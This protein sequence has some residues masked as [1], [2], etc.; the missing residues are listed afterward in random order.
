MT[1]KNLEERKLI[2]VALSELYLD[3]ELQESDLRYMARI[4]LESPF[5]LNK[6][7][8]IDRDEV[9]PVLFSNLLNPTG[10]WGFNEKRLAESIVSWMEKRSKLDIL[11]VHCVYPLYSRVNRSYWKKI[12][13]VYNQA[14]G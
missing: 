10:E 3:I 8:L 2:W 11:A 7:K 6:I 4:F 14:D 13:K 5:D 9:F 12:E 1:E